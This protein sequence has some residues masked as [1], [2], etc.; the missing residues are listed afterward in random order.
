MI[1]EVRKTLR[2]AIYTRKS[3]E[4]GLEM[5]FN[6][7]D[8]Q[9][10]AGENYIASQKCNG[11]ICLPERYDDGGF[12]GGNINRPAL[13]HLLGDIKAGKI[14]VVVIYK[15]DRLSRSIAD[16][17]KLLEIFDRY[18]V[19]FV[20]VTQEINT[21][22][23]AG[24]MMLNVLM[25]FAQY[26]REVIAE[27]VRDKIA[28]A[29]KK[30]MNTGGIPPMGYVSDPLTHK[31]LI[32]HKDAE[33]VRRIYADYLRL[34]SA[35]DVAVGLEADGIRTRVLTSRRGR[36]TGGG[37]FTA[38]LV[39]AV[40][41]N[42][43]YIGNVRHHDKTYP[44]EQEPIIERSVW[45]AAQKLLTQ[46]LRFDGKRQKRVTPLGGLVWCGSCNGLMK[47]NFSVRRSNRH[48][49][50]FVCGKD[51]KRLKSTC[52]LKYIP[53]P[54]LE[55]LVVREVGR[56]LNTPEVLAGV[57]HKAMEFD[58][59]EEHL[60]QEQIQMAFRNLNEVW[61]IM[62]PVEQYKLIHAI[63]SRIIVYPDH[64]TIRFNLEGLEQL[65]HATIG[66]KHP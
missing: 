19:D 24:R 45:N 20:C 23:S 36:T 18:K 58:G 29:K 21:S 30:G 15:L 48:Y 60:K 26:E 2:C 13:Q 31:L 28:A 35:R 38:A 51:E 44:G 63:V 40:L 41:S 16:F 25:S 27:R 56:L 11:W 17:G 1:A 6:S 59:Q 55:K 8:A 49:R 46:N 4:E 54:E 47:E 33:I 37:P 52:P 42:P 34:G 43:M 53:A 50:Y 5:E 12:S 66:G 22:T 14:D 9:R 57:Q 61:E 64:V 39:Y 7:L 32:Q 65:V 62:F 3:T 10:E